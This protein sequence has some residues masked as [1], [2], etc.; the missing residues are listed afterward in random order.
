MS[1]VH[2]RGLCVAGWSIAED[3]VAGQCRAGESTAIESG[4]NDSAVAST[5]N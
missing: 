2:L 4:T 5:Q 1:L 3:T